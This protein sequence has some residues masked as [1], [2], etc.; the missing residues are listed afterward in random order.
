[1]KNV[2]SKKDIDVPYWFIVVLWVFILFLDVVIGYKVMP[3]GKSP[4]FLLIL[5]P[6]GLSKRSINS[7]K[8]LTKKYDI[9]DTYALG[10][11]IYSVH[12][13]NYLLW[14]FSIIHIQQSTIMIFVL[15]IAI[16]YKLGK[17]K[18]GRI[19]ASS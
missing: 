4:A 9:T 13:I 2:L 11:F 1:M 6:I 16:L 14:K 15:I 7:K 18:F 5:L 10:F 17:Y 3:E 8:Y 19:K 12:Y